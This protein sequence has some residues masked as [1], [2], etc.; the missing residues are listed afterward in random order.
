MQVTRTG[1]VTTAV[2]TWSPYGKELALVGVDDGGPVVFTLGP[3][4]TGRRT[5]WASEAGEDGALV[6]Q[7]AWSPTAGT[8][9]VFVTDEIYIIRAGAS[10]TRSGSSSLWAEATGRVV[11][12]TR[13]GTRIAVYEPCYRR[14]NYRACAGVL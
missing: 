7:L 13:D 3:D 9:L 4:G 12:W 5:V 11:A 8:G 6:T 2:P 14:D 10:A 1:D